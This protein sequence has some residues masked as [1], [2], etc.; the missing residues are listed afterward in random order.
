MTKRKRTTDSD[1]PNLKRLRSEVTGISK[2]QRFQAFGLPRSKTVNLQSRKEKR[3]EA[4]HLKKLR[5]LAYSQ[6]KP[7]RIFVLIAIAIIY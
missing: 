5:K 4:R 2:E 3:K 1:Q 6:R 7:V